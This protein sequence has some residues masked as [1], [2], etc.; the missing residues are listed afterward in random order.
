MEGNLKG[1]LVVA[2][3]PV[4][5]GSMYVVTHQ[6]LPSDSPLWGAALRALPAAVVVGI[7]VRKPPHGPW[8][9]RSAVLG[10]LNVSA[11]FLLVY[12]AA[13]LLP[14]SVAASVMA[15]SPVVLMALAWLVAGER[16][17]ILPSVGAALG[18]L[19]VPLIVSA[20]TAP[21]DLKGVLASLGAL[22][23]W[24]LGSVLAKRWND[25]TPAMHLTAWQLAAGG[26]VL[27]PLAVL[28]EGAPPHVGV[29]GVA[30]YAYVALVATA[31]AFACWFSGMQRLPAGTVGVV[32]LLNPTTGVVL[33]V[34]I[35]G[36]RLT[37]LQV[38]GIV[39]VLC[40]VACV[41]LGRSS[42]H[43]LARRKATMHVGA[44]KP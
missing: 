24:S 35:A 11:F 32:G 33:G 44:P 27:T 15:A 19:G 9:W 13:T 1:I 10:I 2:I 30:A 12:L 8:W 22:V 36:E 5:W 7:M 41:T 42:R 3:A 29:T 4:A 17:T 20:G 34:G 16:P 40:A 38:A 39:L 26:A 25:G 37:V 14:S 6:A 43:G 18:M 21:I 31:L 23:M 28:V